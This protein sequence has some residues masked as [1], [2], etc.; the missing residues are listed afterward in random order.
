MQPKQ[1]LMYSS[2]EEFHDWI[3]NSDLAISE[4]ELETNEKKKSILIPGLKDIT[5]YIDF[6]NFF[7]CDT[8]QTMAWFTPIE[9]EDSPKVNVIPIHITSNQYVIAET[10]S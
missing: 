3:V 8:M 9:G 6:V 1:L 5:T 2:R 7:Q 4:S 10:E